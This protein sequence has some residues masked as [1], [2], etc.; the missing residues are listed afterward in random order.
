MLK[1]IY[2]KIICQHLS[3]YCHKDTKLYY[4]IYW[5][6]FSTCSII[7]VNYN[8]RNCD[9]F[10]TIKVAI[11]LSK[12]L[13]FS[14]HRIFYIPHTSL[15]VQDIYIKPGRL[16]VHKARSRIHMILACHAKRVQRRGETYF[17]PKSFLLGLR[18]MGMENNCQLPLNCYICSELN[19]MLSPLEHD[20]KKIFIWWVKSNVQEWMNEWMSS[21]IQSTNNSWV[22]YRNV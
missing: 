1:Y 7:R 12:Y 13:K 4:Y 22:R 16:C 17:L 14:L 3:S 8:W 20:R 19:L 9:N 18:F 15:Y 10:W 6:S 21:F 11:L 2:D 5:S